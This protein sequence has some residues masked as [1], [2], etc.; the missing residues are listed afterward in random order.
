M[1]DD[2]IIQA[3]NNLNHSHNKCAYFLFHCS[4][5]I[6]TYIKNRHK[7]ARSIKESLFM[8]LYGYEEIPKCKICGKPVPFVGRPNKIYCN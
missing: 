7:E 4:D 6:K 3:Y 5:E 2:N 1:T 8:I